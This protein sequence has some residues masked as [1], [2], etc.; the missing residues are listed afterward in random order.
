MAFRSP[1]ETDAAV[2]WITIV[3]CG[4][5]GSVRQAFSLVV[6]VI[7]VV[8]GAVASSGRAA[9]GRDA[10]FDRTCATRAEGPADGPGPP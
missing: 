5:L 4:V 10:P 2:W 9:A 3:G 6:I 1:A 7:A 8:A